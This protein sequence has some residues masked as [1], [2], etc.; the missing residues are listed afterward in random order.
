ME[1]LNKSQIIKILSDRG[2]SLFS[3]RDLARIFGIRKDDTLY[4]KIISLEKE[5]IITKISKGKYLFN[6]KKPHEFEI[7]NFIYQP[8]YVSLESAL[9]LF[10]IITGISHQITSI[11]LKKAKT[12]EFQNQEYVFS[13]IKSEFYD[14]FEKSDN[15]LIATPEKALFDYLWLAFKG[16]RS[17]EIDEFDL[18]KIDWTKFW[19]FCKKSKNSEFLKFAKDLKI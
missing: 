6:F 2:T 9:S 10:G 12:I 15:F 4:K 18:S 7:A 1:P 19:E 5:K 13:E 14:G 17:R 8:S 3:P 16:L 11:S